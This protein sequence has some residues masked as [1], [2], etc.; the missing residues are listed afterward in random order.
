MG[1][2]LRPQ[3]SFFS[4]VRS[5]SA[6]PERSQLQNNKKRQFREVASQGRREQ[7]SGGGGEVRGGDRE[8]EGKAGWGI[9]QTPLHF[10]ASWLAKDGPAPPSR[11]PGA[12]EL[13]SRLLLAF[14]FGRRLHSLAPRSGYASEETTG[15]RGPASL[16]GQPLGQPHPSAHLAPLGD[17]SR[18][19]RL[20]RRAGELSS[21]RLASRAPSPSS[22]FH[23]ASEGKLLKFLEC[24]AP[25]CAPE[26]EPGREDVRKAADATSHSS[27]PHPPLR[28]DAAPQWRRLGIV[29]WRGSHRQ[30]RPHGR[31]RSPSLNRLRYWSLQVL[32]TLAR[33]S[34]GHPYPGR[35][36]S[37]G[38][39]KSLVCSDGEQAQAQPG[40][41][42]FVRLRLRSHDVLSWPAAA[43]REGWS[44]SGSGER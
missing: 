40:S 4:S 16:Q 32:G 28:R 30:R 19:E 36:P 24:G 1:G 37:A 2:G 22:L 29:L 11:G 34:Q 42:C 18:P 21:R 15:T 44:G 8:R 31:S 25:R 10:R 12:Q 43:K 7:R 3:P 41:C 9:G 17:T 26:L 33:Q 20:K 6:P 13:G 39:T 27:V 23:D 35:I 5:H 14:L 38:E